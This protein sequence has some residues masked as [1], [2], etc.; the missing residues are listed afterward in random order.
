M[1]IIK[2]IKLINS[3][4]DDSF[5]RRHELA[6][7]RSGLRTGT[8]PVLALGECHVALRTNIT[9]TTS[10]RYRCVETVSFGGLQRARHS[11]SPFKEYEADVQ[12]SPSLETSRDMLVLVS[13]ERIPDEC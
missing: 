4:L 8:E 9:L 2:T 5:G 12:T 7:E 13:G 10:Y 11:S 3:R 1:T 6:R